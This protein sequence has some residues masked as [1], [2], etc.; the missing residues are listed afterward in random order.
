MQA[1]WHSAEV[2]VDDNWPPE[3]HIKFNSYATRFRSGLDLVLDDISFDI[4]G[5]E[6]V[7]V[8]SCFV[9]FVAFWAITS[10]SVGMVPVSHLY[11]CVL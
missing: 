1:D 6:K 11:V 2:S 10:V 7:C 8:C 9:L 3:G 5:G 4:R